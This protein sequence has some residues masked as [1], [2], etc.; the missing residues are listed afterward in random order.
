MTEEK[1][2]I[3]GEYWRNGNGD[4]C[5]ILDTEVYHGDSLANRIAIKIMGQNNHQISEVHAN[6][7]YWFDNVPSDNDLISIWR[8]PVKVEGYVNVYYLDNKPVFGNLWTT[9]D[10]AE[11]HNTEYGDADRITCVFVRG[12]EV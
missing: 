11:F 1:K 6:G 8:E 9:K 3:V 12:V 2:F 7:S 10:K 5:L 4:K